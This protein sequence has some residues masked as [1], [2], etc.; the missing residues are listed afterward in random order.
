M[1]TNFRI[2]ILD[3]N[4]EK[5]TVNITLK[6]IQVLTQFKIKELLKNKTFIIGLLLP[7]VMVVAYKYGLNSILS[8]SGSE[9]VGFTLVL[10]LGIL[11]SLSML[12]L[13]MPA[14]LIAK[15]KEKNTL[16][17]LMTSSI[18]G[19]EYFMSIIIPVVIVTVLVN[20]LVL[21][22]SGVPLGNVNLFMYTAVIILASIAMAI[23]GMLVGIFSKNQMS[24]SNNMVFFMMIFMMVPMFSDLVK[25]IAPLNNL[26]F[27]G[28][29]GNM[30]TNIAYG[31]RQLVVSSDWLV[32]LVSCILFGIVFLFIYKR[33]GLQRE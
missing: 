11:L 1:R 7:I 21:V 32:L 31:K 10:K 17:V 5:I 27:T 3:S 2:G 29:I 26:L 18:T 25:Q 20:I 19:F 16:R 23:V 28:V 22:L 15:D 33:T 24:A 13:T 8:T 9:A 14:T 6:K 30:A 12:T 4:R